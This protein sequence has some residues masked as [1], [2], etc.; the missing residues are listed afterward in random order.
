P[1]PIGSRKPGSIDPTLQ[2]TALFRLVMSIHIRFRNITLLRPLRSPCG[3]SQIDHR[4]FPAW[5]GQEPPQRFSIAG[6]MLTNPIGWVVLARR[7]HGTGPKL[8]TIAC[9]AYKSTG[10]KLHWCFELDPSTGV[11]G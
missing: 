1:L 11:P 8:L 7:S 6:M 3:I 2:Q 9:Y 4:L 5:R 10:M